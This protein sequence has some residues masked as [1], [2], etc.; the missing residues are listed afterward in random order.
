MNRYLQRIENLGFSNFLKYTWHQKTKLPRKGGFFLNSRHAPHPLYCRAGTSDIDVFKHIF[1]VHE[2]SCLDL[3]GEPELII[4]CG[5]NAGYSSAYLLKRFPTAQVIAIEPDPGNYQSLV[6][7]TRSFGERCVALQA[8][9]WSKTCGLKFSEAPFGDGREWAV[10]VRETTDGE[11]PDVQSV[12]VGSLIEQAGNKRVS[13]LKVDIEGSE[14]AVFDGSHKQW[15]DR[16][17]HIIIEL[18]GEKSTR[19]Y[20]DAVD[21]A[22]F[23]SKV[24][25]GLTLSTRSDVRPA[26]SAG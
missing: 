20:L 5:A 11:V 1:V 26:S 3:P 23:T 4:D 16:V 12:D 2:Y 22:G 13:L 15:I 6:R 9:V 21:A 8:G 25:G 24:V 14:D 19:N 18:H 7:N 17:D 10:S